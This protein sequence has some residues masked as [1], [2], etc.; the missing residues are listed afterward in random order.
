V[1]I[2][3]ALAATPALRV[4]ISKRLPSTGSHPVAP[5]GGSSQDNAEA[6][7]SNV[8]GAGNPAN[9]PI[10]RIIGDYFDDYRVSL[11]RIAG[12]ATDVRF[13]PIRGPVCEDWFALLASKNHYDPA[14]KHLVERAQG[15][16]VAADSWVGRE[17]PSEKF[18][19]DTLADTI[20]RCLCDASDGI[21]IR[22]KDQVELLRDEYDRALRQAKEHREEG[23]RIVKERWTLTSSTNGAA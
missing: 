12:G 21:D 4:Q 16:A 17:S 18:P 15:N 22:L 5:S 14:D 8:A 7:A 10:P 23:W 2:G 11:S 6:T 1:P 20:Y 3:Q 13:L 9:A 19:F